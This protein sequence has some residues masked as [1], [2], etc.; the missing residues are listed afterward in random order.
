ML[1]VQPPDCLTR[2]KSE[3]KNSGSSDDGKMGLSETGRNAVDSIDRRND[4]TGSSKDKV[5]GRVSKDGDVE[6]DLGLC[7]LIKVGRE[8]SSKLLMSRAFDD[9]C[10]CLGGFVL[11]SQNT[12]L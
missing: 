5:G 7:S 12:W 6:H 2:F 8:I 10:W 11:S 3:S 1:F 4:K 9:C